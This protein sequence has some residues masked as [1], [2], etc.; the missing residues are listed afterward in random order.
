VTT[1]VRAV[2]EDR[3][4]VDRDVPAPDVHRSLTSRTGQS[5]GR[6]DVLLDGAR[7]HWRLRNGPR[8][9]KGS[10]PKRNRPPRVRSSSATLHDAECPTEP[11]FG[12]VRTRT[13]TDSTRSSH[14]RA[15]DC[16]DD[17]FSCSAL[18]R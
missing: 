8:K 6:P 18:L 3:R 15:S 11:H 5:W 12:P 1:S 7:V 14:R 10:G 16:E 17:R 9:M 2:D 4:T 13:G